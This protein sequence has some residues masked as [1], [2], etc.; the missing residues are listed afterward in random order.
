[1]A[2]N[3][4]AARPDEGVGSWRAENAVLQVPLGCR[5]C[6]CSSFAE[7]F[8]FFCFSFLVFISGFFGAFWIDSPS[9]MQ[10]GA[11]Q[12]KDGWIPAIHC[13]LL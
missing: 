6:S 11:S 4:A 1:M 7:D 9:K 8:F 10:S 13:S 5:W 3:V 12:Q 2:A